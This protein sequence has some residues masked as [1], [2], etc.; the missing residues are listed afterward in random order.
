MVSLSS[1][2]D[3]K[4]I[5]WYSGD[6]HLHTTYS[7]GRQNVEEVKE[8][9]R[10]VNIDWAVLTDHNTLGGKEEWLNGNGLFFGNR[11]GNFFSKGH[12]Y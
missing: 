12:P 2:C 8:A 7:D 10:A 9:I 3:S 6:A 4:K 1:K 11:S 5:G